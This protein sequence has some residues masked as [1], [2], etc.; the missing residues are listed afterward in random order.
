MKNQGPSDELIRKAKE[1]AKRYNRAWILWVGVDG[2]VMA[3][4]T[5]ENFEIAERASWPEK[6]LVLIDAG[7]G[8]DWYQGPIMRG[9]QAVSDSY[10]KV[11][12][13]KSL[14]L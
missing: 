8:K 6:Q 9:A 13:D 4:P 11:L 12:P 1:D 10:L 2:E 5:K 7:T 14:D 3:P